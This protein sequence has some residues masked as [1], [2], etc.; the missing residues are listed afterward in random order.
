MR[1]KIEKALWF[2][3]RLAG[4]ACPKINSKGKEKSTKSRNISGNDNDY[5]DW[6]LQQNV[7]PLREQNSKL[8]GKGLG[9]QFQEL[10]K[11][12]FTELPFEL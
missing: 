9:F 1:R 5:L 12:L 3:L 11:S 4:S 2:R 7:F 10:F 6:L 8:S